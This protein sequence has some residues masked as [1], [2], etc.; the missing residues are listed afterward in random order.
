MQDVMTIG[1]VK[2]FFR[3]E[4]KNHLADEEI[5]AVF[6]VVMGHFFH[7]GLKDI[8][9]YPSHIIS[10][11]QMAHLTGV[12][13]RLKNGEPVQYILGE[14]EFFGLQL[15]VR[16]G[17]LI[18]RPE[19]EELV[20]WALDDMKIERLKNNAV[21]DIGTGTGC[22]AIALKK[23]FSA[24]T[25]DATDISQTAL[26]LAAENA[27][28]NNTDITFICDS[29]LEPSLKG[30]YHLIISNPPY[31]RISEK[32]RMSPTV[33]NYEPYTAL[34]VP[35]ENPLLFYEAILLFAQKHLYPDGAIYLEINE[36]LKNECLSMFRRFGFLKPGLRYDINGK[37]RMIKLKH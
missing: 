35:D 17:V 18:P 15:H 20:N 16:P 8:Y 28:I 34:F 5:N 6:R 37:P 36:A 26:D 32:D 11:N 31:V 30:N 4:L 27:R 14:T 29:I 19:T 10:Q 25:V 23:F 13:S 7:F 22:I 21:L 12:I 9:L 24:C 1:R 3:A 33:T 2:D